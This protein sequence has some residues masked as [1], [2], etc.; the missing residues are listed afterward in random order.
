MQ[1]FGVVQIGT[2]QQFMLDDEHIIIKPFQ[3]LPDVVRLNAIDFL[4]FHLMT[5][6]V[7][8]PLYV[9]DNKETHFGFKNHQLVGAICNRPF[10]V[11]FKNCQLP[12][13]VVTDLINKKLEDRKGQIVVTEFDKFYDCDGFSIKFLSSGMVYIELDIE[14]MKFQSAL[15]SVVFFPTICESLAKP[16]QPTV[17]QQNIAFNGI[18]F[19]INAEST[20]SNGLVSLNIKGITV[21]S[22]DKYRSDLHEKVKVDLQTIHKTFLSLS[23]KA[24]DGVILNIQ[25]DLNNLKFSPEIV[26]ESVSA[27]AIA[28][29]NLLNTKK[30]T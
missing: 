13:S 21:P 8:I 27:S 10:F 18:N 20:I 23:D 17:F 4:R 30:P 22:E 15:N 9:S 3:D 19:P 5:T 7:A 29:M 28:L 24:K 16:E 14:G 6:D 11:D 25:F 26:S 12:L 2:F 1:Q